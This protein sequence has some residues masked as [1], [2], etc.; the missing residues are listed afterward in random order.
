MIVSVPIYTPP[1]VAPPPPQVQLNVR[2]VIY[3]WKGLDGPAYSYDGSPS[4]F[5]SKTSHA[6]GYDAMSSTSTIYIPIDSLTALTLK[7]V[8]PEEIGMP[9]SF[10][11]FL[12][13]A[14]P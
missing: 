4:G 5:H 13:I 12:N 2:Y 7:L 3:S 1:Q 14:N 6:R 8:T 11:A 9:E 10:Q